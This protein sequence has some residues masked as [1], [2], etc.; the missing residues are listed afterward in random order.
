MR[1]KRKSLSLEEA[2]KVDDVV[3]LQLTD[4]IYDLGMLGFE[5]LDDI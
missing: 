2:Q 3:S 4:D 1:S 5:L